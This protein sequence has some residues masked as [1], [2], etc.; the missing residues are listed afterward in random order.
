MKTI[1]SKSFAIVF[2]NSSAKGLILKTISRARFSSSSFEG[3]LPFSLVNLLARSLKYCCYW[4]RVSIFCLYCTWEWISVSSR[5][6]T[7]VYGR[8]EAGSIALAAVLLILSKVRVK[9]VSCCCTCYYS[10]WSTFS[11]SMICSEQYIIASSSLSCLVCYEEGSL[12][13]S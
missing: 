11:M 1:I 2:K 8:V 6:S 12:R 10:S 4:A 7:S 3:S 13:T 9:R 5:S